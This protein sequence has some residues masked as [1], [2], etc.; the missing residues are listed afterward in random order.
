[1]AG[2]TGRRFGSLKQ[3]EP[4]AGRRVL[5]W[6]ISAAATV[7][8]VV[9]V[10][11]A[12]TEVDGQDRRDVP[13][14][15]LG[16]ATTTVTGAATRSGSV[17]CGL[18]AVPG[19]AEVILVHDGARPL[20][21]ATLFRRVVDAVRAGAPVVVPAVAVIDTLRNRVDASVVDREQLVGVQTPQGFAADVLRRAHGAGGEATDDAALAQGLGFEV[22]LVAGEAYNLKITTPEDLV[23]AEALLERR[24]AGQSS[25]AVA[26]AARTSGGS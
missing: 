11:P 19:D 7:G 1:M 5:D 4:V 13:V 18:A 14:D 8:A 3:F 22:A 25:T 6:S 20:A 10:V 17:R 16:A 26:R 12:S 21:D 24:L 9:A 2:G 15:Q 23:V